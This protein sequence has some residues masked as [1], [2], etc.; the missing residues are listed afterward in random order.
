M[1]QDFYQLL[2]MP[3]TA[4][5]WDAVQF[6]SYDGDDAALFVF[7]GHGS[8]RETVRL[9]GLQPDADYSVGRRPQ[10]RPHRTRGSE[11]MAEGLSVDLSP[12]E[13]CMWRITAQM[14]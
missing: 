10:G 7:A 8:G 3:K 14:A 2:P 6:V 13:G 4:D 11:L 9:R 12:N 5:D 1:V